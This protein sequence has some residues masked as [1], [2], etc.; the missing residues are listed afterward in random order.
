M[1]ETGKNNSADKQDKSFYVNNV[2]DSKKD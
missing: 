1:L 2:N